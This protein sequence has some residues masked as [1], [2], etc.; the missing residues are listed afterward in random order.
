MVS[1]VVRYYNRFIIFFT[2]I[3]TLKKKN[4]KKENIFNFTVQYL[5]K[6]SGTVQQHTGIVTEWTEKRAPGWRKERRWEMVELKD[7]QQQETE[8][9][10]QF[11]S[12][13]TLMAQV[14]VPCWNQMQA[15]ITERSQREGSYVADLLCPTPSS[16]SCQ[17]VR[18]VLQL[19]EWACNPGSPSWNIPGA[20]EP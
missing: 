5:E 9:K 7:H 20:G 2:Q 8:G 18:W 1:Y 4:K 19:W 17:W 14:L 16:L 15:R 13:L 6:Y 12:G 11:H 10:L 3:N